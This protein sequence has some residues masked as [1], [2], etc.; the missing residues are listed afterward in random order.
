MTLRTFPVPDG[1]EGE[2]VDIALARMTG[3]SR[4]KVGEL[5]TH[6]A[7]TLAGKELGKSERVSAGQFLDVDMPAPRPTE[8]VATPVDNMGIIYIDDH[9][10]VVDKPAGIA[11]H[12][13]MGWDG[14]DVLGAL[15]AMSITVSTSGA[16][17]RQGIVSR[18]DVGTSGIMIVARSEIAY[19]VLKNAFRHH[20]VDKTY[21]ALVHGHMDPMSGTIDAPIGRHPSREW[22]M[23][24]IDGGRESRTHYDTIEAMP[25]AS[26]LEIELETGRTHQIRVHTSAMGHPCLG[27]E[28]YG[29]DP[30]LTEKTGLTRQWLH[31]VG[32]GVAHPVTG[33]WMIW[34]SQYPADL[35]HALDVV[36]L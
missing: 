31:A 15:K 9:I 23:A 16:A 24:I 34:E 8:P 29:A 35:Q 21:H 26:L 28:T 20:T 6:G 33:E 32:L 5:C 18:L 3:L 27:D 22:K 12:P 10:V 11:A 14:P 19:S 36:R 1:L 13:S 30:V 2:R 4:S 7:V 25:G 17:E